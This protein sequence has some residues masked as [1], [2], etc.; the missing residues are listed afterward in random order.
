M[1]APVDFVGKARAAWGDNAPGWVLALAQACSEA[2]QSRV[3]ARLGVSA[4][5]I[6]STIA[7]KYGGDMER[8]AELCRGEFERE[9]VAC[10]V[11]G[12]IAPL[13]CRRWQAKAGRLRTGNNQNARMFRACRA[14][15]RYRKEESHDG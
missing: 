3:A 13:Q 5:M 6:S 1:I 9:T 15:P 14:C 7:N 12:D 2:S 10:P 4:S 11:F 8:L